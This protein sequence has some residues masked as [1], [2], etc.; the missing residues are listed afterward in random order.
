LEPPVSTWFVSHF[1]SHFSNDAN[2]IL[3]L[4][5]HWEIEMARDAN[6]PSPFTFWAKMKDADGRHVW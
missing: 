3:N 5:N 4:Q 2:K 6:R 1:V